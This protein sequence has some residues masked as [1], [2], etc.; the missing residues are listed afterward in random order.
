MDEKVSISYKVPT[1]YSD[2]LLVTVDGAN[3]DLVVNM[4]ALYESSIDLES[5][6]STD[7]EFTLDD[8]TN[9][10]DISMTVSFTAKPVIEEEESEESELE[11]VPVFD[12]NFNSD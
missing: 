2:I 9:Q 7:L 4:K 1:V 12:P 6:S 10:V 5:G 11:E 8:E 3:I